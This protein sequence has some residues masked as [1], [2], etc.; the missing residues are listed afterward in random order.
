MDSLNSLHQYQCSILETAQQEN[1]RL[2]EATASLD[3][4]KA[5]L[6]A[7]TCHSK[8]LKA[9]KT[10]DQINDQVTRMKGQVTRLREVTE[11]QATEKAE[12]EDRDKRRDQLLSPVIRKPE[13]DIKL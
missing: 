3:M 5:L 9:K 1:L 6:K 2:K 11:K 10:M 4:D 7:R 8:L 12:R 13:P